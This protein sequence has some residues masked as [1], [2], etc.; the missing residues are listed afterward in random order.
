MRAAVP[1]LIA[2]I[3]HSLTNSAVNIITQL[4]A[5]DSSWVVRK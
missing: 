2:A 3:G 4:M 1:M 5:N